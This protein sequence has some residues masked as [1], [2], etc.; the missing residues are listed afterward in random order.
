MYVHICIP[1]YNER[2]KPWFVLLD[3][4]VLGAKIILGLLCHKSINSLLPSKLDLLFYL[5]SD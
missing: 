5:S 3:T 4:D 2:D 1:M